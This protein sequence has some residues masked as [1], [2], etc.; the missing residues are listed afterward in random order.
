MASEA[1]G[2]YRNW[3]AFFVLGSVNNL[4]YVVVNS[5]AKKIVEEFHSPNLIGAIPWANNLFGFL[6][7]A[8]NAFGLQNV[9]YKFRFYANAILMLL[10]LLAIAYAPSLMMA[11]AA[12]V[13]VGSSSSFGESFSLGYLRLYPAEMVGGWSS[14]TGMAGVG[15]AAL[16]MVFSFFDLDNKTSFLLCVPFVA[17]YLFFYLILEKP[18]CEKREKRRS[19]HAEN[20]REEEESDLLEE[21]SYADRPLDRRGEPSSRKEHEEESF[22]TKFMRCTNLVSWVSL[23]LF[24]VYFFEYVISSGFASKC[25][26]KDLEHRTEFYYKD[27]FEILSFCYQFGVFISRSSLKFFKVRKIEVLTVL[28]GLN[29]ALWLLQDIYKTFSVWFLYL[30]MVF[31]GL[32][33]GAAY[34]NIFYLIIND[35]R[36][37]GRDKDLCVNITAMF[38]TLGITLACAFI[39]F[40]DNTFLAS[41]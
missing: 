21:S 34:V 5:A 30:H 1:L 29:F 28:Q 39:L 22:C 2:S 33:G 11:L 4:P 18:M 19:G 3:V 36:I 10:G 16:Y 17:I 7:R 26:P 41:A 23:N 9:P 38:I 31:V 8:V 40:A 13:V 37:M 24:L 14:G 35:Q 12:I 15:G 32:L 27:S 20:E 25:L 6:A